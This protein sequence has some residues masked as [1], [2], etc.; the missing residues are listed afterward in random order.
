MTLAQ[1]LSYNDNQMKTFAEE[2]IWVAVIKDANPK[3]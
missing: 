1:T 3:S 2:I